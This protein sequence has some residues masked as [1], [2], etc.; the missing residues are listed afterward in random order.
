MFGH[1]TYQRALRPDEI[2]T[3]IAVRCFLICI[4][5]LTKNFSM[6]VFQRPACFYMRLTGQCA[7]KAL[8]VQKKNHIA[9]LIICGRHGNAVGKKTRGKF[10]PHNAAYAL[11]QRFSPD[12]ELRYHKTRL[13]GNAIH[14]A[15]TIQIFRNDNTG[16]AQTLRR[17]TVG[18]YGSHGTLQQIVRHRRAAAARD[19]QHNKQ[20]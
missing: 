3:S 13:P 14:N 10:F 9:A 12:I 1:T 17:Q 20:K 19:K 15:V 4:H 8:H 5:T 6:F 2:I 16:N 18:F 7:V 11:T